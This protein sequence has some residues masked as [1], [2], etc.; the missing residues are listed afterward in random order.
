MRTIITLHVKLFVWFTRNMSLKM[1]TIVFPGQGSQ[2]LGMAEDFYDTY[3]EA[4]EVFNIVESATNIPLKEII[5]NDPNKVLNL[6]KYT[7]LCI[8]TVSMAIYRVFC[9]EFKN[10]HFLDIN[11]MLGHS[12]GEY[13]ALVASNVMNIEDC[14]S[15]L[16]NGFV[17]Q[18]NQ[19]NI[20]HLKDGVSGLEKINFDFE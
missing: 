16:A 3:E 15:I 10:T 13:S 17:E 8:F 20:Y 19:T 9:K 11:T 7:Q 18:L 12:L 6:T 14:A 1:T 2:Y 5:F 4:R